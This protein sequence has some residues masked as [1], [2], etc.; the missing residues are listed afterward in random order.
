M[1]RRT[2]ATESD[3]GL[4]LGGSNPAMYEGAGAARDNSGTPLGY[5]VTTSAFSAV[6]L[7]ASTSNDA[8]GCKQE[9]EDA[10]PGTIGV[11]LIGFSW[12]DDTL[13]VDGSANG[14]G[15][16]ANNYCICYVKDGAQ[17]TSF[18]SVTG[19]YGDAAPTGTYGWSYCYNCVSEQPSS[20]PSGQ[21]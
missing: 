19:A 9:C 8:A 1:A 3:P 7:G 5:D 4:F 15:S 17:T 16:A 12:Y 20:Q 18:G 2:A 10:H 14:G 6:D 13:L 21:P 11:T